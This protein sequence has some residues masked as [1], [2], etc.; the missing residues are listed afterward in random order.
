MAARVPNTT[1]ISSVTMA[2]MP[3]ANTSLV[4]TSGG[5]ALACI[6]N[7][8][9][10]TGLRS[11]GAGRR[12]LARFRLSHAPH[13][14]HNNREMGGHGGNGSDGGEDGSEDDADGGNR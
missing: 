14:L 9:Y 5:C 2:A 6:R 13:F 7:Q 11:R 8:Y 1:E 10:R 12:L 3:C 4:S